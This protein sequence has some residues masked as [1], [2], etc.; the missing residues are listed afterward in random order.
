MV[1]T[2]WIGGAL[3]VLVIL[4]LILLRR[5]IS[6]WWNQ[7]IEPNKPRWTYLAAPMVTLIQAMV[8]VLAAACVLIPTVLTYLQNEQKNAIERVEK[9]F[10]DVQTRLSSPDAKTRAVAMLQLAELAQQPYPQKPTLSA[11]FANAAIDK[12][13]PFSRTN[14]PFFAR[15]AQQYATTL[16]MEEEANVRASTKTAVALLCTFAKDKYTTKEDADAPGFPKGTTETMVALTEMANELAD[17]NRAAKDTF[18]KAMA[19]YTVA[20]TNPF[21]EQQGKKKFVKAPKPMTTPTYDLLVTTTNFCGTEEKEKLAARYCIKALMDTPTYQT[22]WQVYDATRDAMP[23]DAAR[24]KADGVLLAEVEKKAWQLTDT[25]DA[26]SK[27]LETLIRPAGFPATFPTDP[28]M[29][30]E[31]LEDKRDKDNK[32]VKPG[33]TRQPAL[34]LS[35]C[36]LAGAYLGQAQLQGADLSEAQLQ[37]A[38]LSEAQL[39]RARLIT[40]RLQRANLSEA[41]LQRAYLSGARLQR[42]YLS[43]AQLQG[44]YLSLAQLQGADLSLAQLQGAIINLAR[45]QGANLSEAQLQGANLSEA[46]LQ[47]ANLF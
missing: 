5:R 21:V 30:S 4:A 46:Q 19:N 1:T 10:T 14:F 29:A 11:L 20:T 23:D 17:A 15:A 47:G 39:Q 8:A 27:S 12:S 2:L 45:L 3:I 33:W 36:F 22:Q 37:G 25:R 32:V 13:L 18:I 24:K 44:A 26:L 35:L 41:Q 42:A 31:F 43:G 9:Q 6:A 38:D 28:K 7:E 16:P 34:A 40:A